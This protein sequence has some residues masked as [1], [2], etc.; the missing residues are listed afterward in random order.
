MRIHLV[1]L[2]GSH[3]DVL[4][5]M[6]EHYRAEGVE[7]FSVNVHLAHDDDR[8]LDDVRSVTVRAGIDIESVY[9]G[10]WQAYETSA[11]LASMRMHPD[12]WWVLA[13]QDEL[14][15]YPDALPSLLAYCDQKGYDH[16]RGGIVDR[17]D[18]KG[19]LAAV[20]VSRPLWPQFPLGGLVSPRFCGWLQM[21]VIAAKGHVTITPGHHRALAGHECPM[22]EIFVEV[23]HFKWT[24]GLIQR[25][26]TR[27]EA[28]RR[29]SVPHWGECAR[30]VEYLEAHGECI[31]VLD[32]RFMCA[33][34]EP[35]YPH[36]KLVTQKLLARRRGQGV[37]ADR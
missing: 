10:N 4:P 27:A 26:A 31:D 33:V 3:V 11:W 15:L 20:D 18:E 14:Q 12:D 17:L 23:H 24:A 29:K 8:V 25:Q 37:A 21:K 1:T 16:I 30:I 6:L 7:L 5:H 32:R 36:W 28:F 34:C 2:I 35:S 9:V 13:D 22:E 19:Y